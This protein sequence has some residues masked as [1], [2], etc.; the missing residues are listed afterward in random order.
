MP[1]T[2]PIVALF[3]ALGLAILILLL[4]SGGMVYV[5]FRLM[6]EL[7]ATRKALTEEQTERERWERL[8]EQLRGYV[9]AL[10]DVLRAHG[11]PLPASVAADEALTPANRPRVVAVFPDLPGQDLLDY[12][13]EQ[14]ILRESGGALS[15]VLL[16]G[17]NA[18]RGGIAQ[19]L[20]LGKG[21]RLLY[22]ASH[23]RGGRI[24]LSDGEHATRAWLA[25]VIQSYGI[26]AVVLNACHSD[27]LAAAC[28]AAGAEVVIT[29]SDQIADREAGKLAVGTIQALAW[30]ETVR[31]AVDYALM[32]VDDATAEIIRLRGDESWT[33]RDA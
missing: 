24:A 29:T 23:G 21:A 31:R 15:P 32:N 1:P 30:G 8:A 2:W 13:E 14:R 27:E 17:A 25:L 18:T 9:Q 4:V 7:Q 3:V 19:E 10:L 22:I 28:I 20:H 33:W 16:I 5:A 26:K 6:D 12:A 11:V